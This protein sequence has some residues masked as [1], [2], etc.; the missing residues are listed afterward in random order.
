MEAAGERFYSRSKYKR[1][2]KKNGQK[3]I[4]LLGKSFILIFNHFAALFVSRADDSVCL[5]VRVCGCPGCCWTL[6]GTLGETRTR[7][8]LLCGSLAL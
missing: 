1:Q 5:C 8:A 7:P 6:H 3:K 4:M 2:K